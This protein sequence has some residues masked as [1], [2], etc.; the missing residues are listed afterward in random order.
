M[1][2]ALISSNSASVILPVLTTIIR[3]VQESFST[4]G[5]PKI[6]SDGRLTSAI[7]LE[8]GLMSSLS[9]LSPVMNEAAQTQAQSC[10]SPDAV[11][12]WVWSIS[13][14]SRPDSN[15]ETA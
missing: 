11:P 3:T 9:R 14:E 8:L 15:R 4:L 5:A 12:Q 6:L 13:Q 10:C 2:P 7:D 1:Y